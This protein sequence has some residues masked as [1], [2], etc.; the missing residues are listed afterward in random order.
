MSNQVPGGVLL[1]SYSFGHT[2]SVI[3]MCFI[4]GFQ[5]YGQ[6]ALCCRL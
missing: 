2:R 4:L 6:V 5:R 1:G 3:Q